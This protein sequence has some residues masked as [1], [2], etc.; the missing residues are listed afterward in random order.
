MAERTHTAQEV[1]EAVGR[2]MYERDWC[3]QA[4]GIVL[5][6]IAPGFARMT[7][8]VRKDMVNGHD[9]CHGGMTFTLADT[10][11]AYACNSGNEATVAASCHISFPAPGRLGDVLT[12]EAREVHRKG[13][14]GVYDCIITNQDGVVVGIF[15]GQSAAVKGHVVKLP[16]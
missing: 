14:S 3:A 16:D 10:A 12:A 1:A 13:R 9:S 6:E 7:M 5:T 2:G 11:F 15:R 4:H 8:T